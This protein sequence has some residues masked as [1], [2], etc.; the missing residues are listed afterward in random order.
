MV[1]TI[2][3]SARQYPSLTPKKQDD[4]HH[5]SSGLSVSNLRYTHF[6]GVRVERKH[7][8]RPDDSGRA[9]LQQVH[10]ADVQRPEHAAVVQVHVHHVDHGPVT[11]TGAAVPVGGRARVRRH[12]RLYGAQARVVLDGAERER[13]A[14]SEP[15]HGQVD[16]AVVSHRH[17]GR[18]HVAGHVLARLGGP[19]PVAGP[20]PLEVRPAHDV[21]Q[22]GHWQPDPVHRR[23]H[24]HR[25]CSGHHHQ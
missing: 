23:R 21:R 12:G 14:P 2:L 16:D 13:H 4:R 10:L 9:V 6:V 5:T 18:R 15:G 25:C 8:R 7:H 1:T 24:H 17:A 20:R 19:Q 22:P 3:V 11:R